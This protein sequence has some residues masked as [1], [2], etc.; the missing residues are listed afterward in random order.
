VGAEVLKAGAESL[1]LCD[2][3]NMKGS[4]RLLLELFLQEGLLSEAISYLGPILKRLIPVHRSHT[5]I[6]ARGDNRVEEVEI[7]G[8]DDDWKPVPG[9]ERTYRVD[10]VGLGFGFQP[11]ARLCR[12]ADCQLEFDLNQRVFKPVVDSYMR[13]SR[14]NI[15]VAGDSGGIGGSKM[16]SVEGQLAAI[17]AASTFETLTPGELDQAHKRLT[18]EKKKIARYIT[19]LDEMFTPRS[20]IFD[21]IQEETVICRCEETTAADFLKAIEMKHLNLNAIKKRTR[22]GMGPCQGKSCEAIAVEMG[23]RT[24]VTLSELDHLKIRPPITPIPMSVM[25]RYSEPGMGTM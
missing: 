10:V 22:L 7:A 23:L 3:S 17:H 21:I 6:A 19:C 24:G 5:I 4:F 12:L 8:L 13:T 16:A 15:Y 1:I 2:A 9:T 18:R 11:M 14:P 25:S 20:G